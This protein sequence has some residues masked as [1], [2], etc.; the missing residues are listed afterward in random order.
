MTDKNI[1]LNQIEHFKTMNNVASGGIEEIFSEC[2]EVLDQMPTV[3]KDL[4]RIS[5]LMDKIYERI[6]KFE[7]KT[8]AKE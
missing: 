3:K 6:E 8:E 5:K 7:Q 1:L 2:S 4:I